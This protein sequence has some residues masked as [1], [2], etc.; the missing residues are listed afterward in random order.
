MWSLPDI[1]RLNA[2]AKEGIQE[3]TEAECMYCEKKHTIAY[4][5][6]DIFSD[7]P[8]GFIYLC[9]DHDNYY[10]SPAEGYFYCDSCERTMVEN[11]TWENYYHVYD[12][13]EIACLNCFFDNEIQDPANWILKTDYEKNKEHYTDFEYI[14]TRK[15]L[16]PNSGNHWKSK[17]EF[18]DNFEFDAMDGHQ[19]SGYSAAEN[20]E[21]ALQ[22]HDKCILILDSAYQFAVSIGVYVEKK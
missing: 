3:D 11:Y 16:I 17:L 20:I 13:G 7:D 18:I 15:H 10:G 19:I 9:E 8:K 14:R 12:S 2:A 22:D 1:K 4:E 6:Y 21:K 5:Y